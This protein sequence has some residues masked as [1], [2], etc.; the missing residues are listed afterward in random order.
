MRQAIQ[1]GRKLL[2]SER[3]IVTP[4]ARDLAEEHGSSPFPLAAVSVPGS[5]QAGLRR[6]DSAAT[7]LPLTLTAEPVGLIVDPWLGGFILTSTMERGPRGPSP[8]E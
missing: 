4:A 5:C 6:P 3:A 2:I 7:N 8:R 1:A